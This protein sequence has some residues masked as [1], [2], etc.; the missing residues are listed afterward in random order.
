MTQFEALRIL[1]RV[2]CQD[3]GGNQH[4][5]ITIKFLLVKV[6]NIQQNHRCDH[7]KLGTFQQFSVPG[8][9]ATNSAPCWA[10]CWLRNSSQA[11]DSTS[12]C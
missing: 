4:C 2:Y 8:A 5:D 9:P 11:L 12:T 7:L 1:I 10:P 3:G 6:Y